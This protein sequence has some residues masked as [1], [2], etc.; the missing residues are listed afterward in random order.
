VQPGIT[1]AQPNGD[2]RKQQ[3]NVAWDSCSPIGHRL[4]P[5]CSRRDGDPEN[6]VGQAPDPG[7]GRRATT[8]TRS[9]PADIVEKP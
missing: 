7:S 6:E 5:S 4:S 1:A 2:G 9:Y 3:R 8:E